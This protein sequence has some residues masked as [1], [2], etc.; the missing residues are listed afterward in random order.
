MT[1]TYHYFLGLRT[2]TV[3]RDAIDLIKDNYGKE[4][5][6]DSD[7]N[8]EDPEV[9]EMFARAE[10]LGIFQFESSGMRSFLKE[11]KPNVF[12]NL[13]AANSLYRPGPMSQ[14]PTFVERKHD[15]SKI[16]YIHPKLESILKPT[17]GVI[18][19][20]EQV[21]EIVQKIGGYSLGHADI[22]RRAMGKKDMKVMEEERQK[23]IYGEEDSEGNV[24]TRGA[25]KNGVDEKSASQIYDLMIEFANYAF[26][27]SHSAAYA[28]VAYRTAWLKHYYPVE[29]MAAL[30]SSIMGNTSSVSL[31]IQE[32]KR[33]G[34]DILRPD[35]NESKVK[36]TVT[37]GKIRFGLSAVK[38]VGVK[39]IDAIVN[40]R[41][42][43]EFKSLTDFV[44]RVVKEDP[45]VI[46][47]RA[48]ESLIKCGAMD[49][50]GGN[51][52][53]YLSIYE[54]TIDG[55]NDDRKRN[56]EGQFSIFDTVESEYTEDDLP[57]LR[58]FPKNIILSMEKE[59][60]GIYISGHPLEPYKEELEKS[61]SI[62]T[63]ELVQSETEILDG[64]P[65]IRDGMRVTLGGM[66]SS[67]KN[68]LTKNNNMMAFI[69]IEDL[70]GE[71][72]CMVFPT[73]YERYLE[74]LEEDSFVVVS[75]KITISE[76]DNAQIII[77]KIRE[78]KT[79]ADEKLYLKL[80]SIKDVEKL[81]MVKGE[82]ARSQGNIPVFIYFEEEEKS[83]RAEDELWIKKDESLTG[84]LKA[85]LGENSV[86]FV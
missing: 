78:L 11:L 79:P 33:L 17:Y 75:G 66:I 26:N 61:S 72:E 6:F 59:I 53:Q 68:M 7:F 67:R 46:N 40:A 12:E 35:I 85:L 69:T 76:V 19:Y 24:L 48:V 45:N 21:M 51:R 64:T 62:N 43:G 38:N 47:K 10:T 73:T 82:L 31:Y 84:K 55:I 22:L 83:I 57:D 15:P 27:K 25:I 42:D 28:V 70:F 58:Y 1:L 23:F 39:F 52:A 32:C 65:T 49:W 5:I 60:A 4:I 34:I 80:N 81:K 2:L 14:I 54:K 56:I 29:F 9:L 30:I 18:T 44:E 41:K 63:V 74:Y 20:Q 36:F 71:V 77:E 50:L 8:Y 13:I 3:I 86:K 37:D 16:K